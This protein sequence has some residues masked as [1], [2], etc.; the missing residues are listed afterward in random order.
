MRAARTREGPHRR[1]T[2]SPVVCVLW[3]GRVTPWIDASVGSPGRLLPLCLIGQRD[4]PATAEQVAQS[5]RYCALISSRP[6]L[7]IEPVCVGYGIGP[8][9]PRDWMVRRP[10]HG[11]RVEDRM[12]GPVH[13]RSIL[14]HGDLVPRKKEGGYVGLAL[15]TAVAPPLHVEAQ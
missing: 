8:G 12:I 9:D 2:S 7:L 14:R 10:F 6:Q 3:L 1:R 4:A 15:N 11:L 13:E 5:I